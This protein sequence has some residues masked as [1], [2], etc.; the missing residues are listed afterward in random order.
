M[1]CLDQGW[2]TFFL[3]GSNFLIKK[4]GGPNLYLKIAKWAKYGLYLLFNTK[5]KAHMG[6]DEPLVGHLKILA[7]P[8]LAPG[9]QV[10]H[11]WNFSTM[12]PNLFELTEYQR[13]EKCN[14]ENYCQY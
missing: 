8:F 1:Y 14:F 11:P 3:E 13:F 10:G 12:V 2:P 7:R 4:L 6:Q 5:L 9:P